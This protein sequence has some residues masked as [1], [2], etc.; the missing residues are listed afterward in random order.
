MLTDPNND[1]RT[2][3]WGHFYEDGEAVLAATATPEANRALRA[4]GR[5]C[6]I[7]KYQAIGFTP[8]TGATATREDG[9][10]G[11]SLVT[12]PYHLPG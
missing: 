8:W 3:F 2:W 1:A 10:L 12:G 4:S 11:P 9:P 5:I 6:A 7:A